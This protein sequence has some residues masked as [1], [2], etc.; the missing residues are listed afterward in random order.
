[1][2]DEPALAPL[3][4]DLLEAALGYYQE[5]L[6][7][8]AGDSQL[9]VE[10]AAAH[11]RS[12]EVCHLI[13]RN[14]EAI[15]HLEQCVRL[16]E[17]LLG[18]PKNSAALARQLPGLHQAGR[19][20][21][22]GTRPPSNPEAAHQTLVR[23][24]ELWEQLA[25]EHPDA[26]GFQSDLAGFHVLTG[27][28]ARAFSRRSE[29]RQHYEQAARILEKL[30][31]EH[32]RVANFRADLASCQEVLGLLARLE[33]RIAESDAA[34]QR[35]LALREE[36]VAEFPTRPGLRLELAIAYRELA[37]SVYAQ[38]LTLALTNLDR[39]L[40][41][42]K[43]PAADYPGIPAYEE[44]LA[45]VQMCRADLHWQLADYEHAEEASQT[46]LAAFEQLVSRFPDSPHYRERLVLCYLDLLPRLLAAGR[47][48]EARETCERIMTIHG[49][50]AGEFDAVPRYH[51]QFAWFLVTCPFVELRDAAQA[52]SSARRAVELRPASGE[53]W[54]VLG[55]ALYRAGNW[56]E[57]C[58]ALNKSLELSPGPQ[59]ANQLFLAM[60][61]WQLAQLPP[62]AQSETPD[63]QVWHRNQAR[64]LYEQAIAWIRA[65]PPGSE[66]LH[67]LKAEASG[68]LGMR[69]VKES[70]SDQPAIQDRNALP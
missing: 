69:S 8:R 60:A 64:Q 12:G 44:Q 1:L 25:R 46:A 7:E 34:L 35:S 51:E 15:A 40:D 32:P 24:A 16:V 26:V 62:D 19:N 6:A 20:L 11:F 18:D 13:D 66:G 9:K 4:K 38:E 5:F 48:A 45:L 57:A 47:S 21:H 28:L 14:D 58:D 61:H 29:A 59:G 37:T 42:L 70:I 50:L 52:V 39:A 56:S 27:D 55:A 65:N 63:E 3:R 2:L 68:L 30:V 67:R 10:L 53:Y 31:A 33:G 17:E 49:S 41:V 22:G 36:L 23:A 54:K 43:R